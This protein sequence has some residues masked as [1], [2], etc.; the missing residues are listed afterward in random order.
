MLPL[1]NCHDECVTYKSRRVGWSDY[2]CF[3]GNDI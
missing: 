3:Q 1:G 2:F